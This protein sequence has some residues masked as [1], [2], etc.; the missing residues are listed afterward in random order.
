MKSNHN[1]RKFLTLNV[2]LLIIVG[3]IFPLNVSAEF[4]IFYDDGVI[5]DDFKNGNDVLLDNCSLSQDPPY[6]ITLKYEPINLTYNYREKPENIKAWKIEDTL[7]SPGEGGSFLQLLSKFVTPNLIPGY[8]FLLGDYIDIK[9]RN[10]DEAAETYSYWWRNLNYTSY[11]MNLFRFTID[12]DTERI[13][14]FWISWQSGDFDKNANL[15]K[16]TMYIWSYGDLLPRWNYIHEIKYDSENITYPRGQITEEVS[17]SRY[18]SKEGGIDVLI[19]GTPTEGTGDFHRSRLLSDYIEVKLGISKG[20]R[21]NGF[22]ISDPIKPV[23]SKFKGWEN[24]FWEGSSP[25]NATNLKIQVLDK[26]NKLIESLEGNSDGFTTSPIDLSSL[27]KEYT[28]IRLKA[29]LK[30][31]NPQFTPYIDSWG[32]LWRTIDGFF[33][34]FNFTYRVRE[35][36]GVNIEDGQ[37]KISSFYSEWPFF[38]KNS[39]NTRSYIGPDPDKKNNKTYWTTSINKDFGGWFRSPVMSNGKLYIASNNNRISAF[40]LIA[41]PDTGIQNPVDNSL[42][43]YYVESSLAIGKDTEGNEYVILA[44]SELDSNSNKIVALDANDLSI[45]LWSKTPTSQNSICFSSSP[46]IANDKIFL[47]SWS[48]RFGDVPQIYYVLSRVNSILGN[49]LGLN[50]YLYALNLTNGNHAWSQIGRPVELPAGSLSSPAVDDGKVFVGC[51]NVK[52]SS[53]FAF[54][55]INGELIWEA[56]VGMIGRSSP[57]VADSENG[58]VVIVLSREQNILSFS[59]EDKVYALRGETGEILWNKTIGNE[60]TLLRGTLLKGLDFQNLVATSEP[61]ATPAVSGDTVFV[62]APNG[63]LHA[64]EVETGK[65]KWTFDVKQGM[66]GLLSSYYCSSPAVVGNTLYISSQDGKVYAINANNGELKFEYSIE[67]EGIKFPLLLYFYSSPIFTDGVVA[68]SATE[69]L[70]IGEKNLGHLI[71]LGAYNMNS[72]GRICSAPIH[73]Q[74]GT[75]WNKFKASEESTKTNT[76]TYSILDSDGNILKEGLNGSNNDISN[77][78]IF[79]TGIIKICAELEMTN[80]SPILNDWRVTFSSETIE[81]KFRGDTFL[82]DP[83]GWINSNKPVCTIQVYD[84]HPGLDVTSAKYRL[85]Y[86]NN[87]K[88]TWYEAEC[89]GINGTINNQTVTAD[90]TKIEPEHDIKRIEISIKDLASNKA[91]YELPED[92]KLDTLTPE[93]FIESTLSEQYNEPF[94]IKANAS[95][96]GQNQS[97]VKTISLYY[98]LEGQENWTQYG[99]AE[100][101]YEWDFDIDI[102]GLYEV[103]PVATDRAGNIEEFPDEV[104][105]YF[106][107]DKTK[108]FKPDL[109]E[110][111]QFAELPELSVEFSDDYLLKDVEYRLSFRGDWININDDDINKETF[112]G[113]WTLKESDWDYME[114]DKIYYIYFRITDSA[115]NEYQTISDTEALAIIKDTIPPGTQVDLDLS[116]MEGGGW[117]DKYTIEAYVPY[118]EDIGY[119]ILEY[120]Y[121]PDDDKWSNWKEYGEKLNKSVYEWEFTAEE[122]S[123]YYEFRIKVFDYAGNYVES[124]PEKVSI[125]L[126]QSYQIILLIALFVIF[127][128][129]TRFITRKMIKRKA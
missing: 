47:T 45:E 43:K 21:S 64:F 96:P 84:D 52:G 110:L 88:S 54:D 78:K 36:L 60:S 80:K 49:S 28:E 42:D 35:K 6:I 61:A 103:C 53:L 127:L 109:K 92:F 113:E 56:S 112:V 55:E 73:V 68:V 100:S 41:D 44:T 85:I 102:S 86:K 83:G 57:V 116:D 12:E 105:D 111:Y 125:T 71:T 76:I 91:T 22:V 70:P 18:I 15:E 124:L 94:R 30:S 14:D 9:Y 13:D 24:I 108:P 19:V 117:K 26:D 5:F 82:P 122:G 99:L 74:S 67:F 50:N 129:I 31:E 32:V 90:V 25:G 8:E 40:N 114:D 97:G 119:V 87:E 89:T 101:P 104:E 65:E 3:F 106:V 75:W 34:S 59:G 93:S 16:I 2:F 11:P 128:F 79:N 27:G 39:R 10:D 51:E 95:D 46:T 126:L 66:K 123:G 29:L 38:G 7:I 20:Y 48:G 115:G 58:K 4:K 72:Y 77:P 33:D 118:D 62:M 107:Y 23:S 63:T 69:L 37:V 121:S 17:G 81:P 120:R 1:Y 98:R